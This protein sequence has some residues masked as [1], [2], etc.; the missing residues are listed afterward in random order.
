MIDAKIA[1]LALALSIERSVLVLTCRSKLSA[2]ACVIAVLAHAVGIVLFGFVRAL[3]YNFPVLLINLL[4]FGYAAAIAAFFAATADL[5]IFRM[6][7]LA[8][9]IILT[10][11][12]RA[13]LRFRY[14]SLGFAS[15]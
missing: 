14:T 3:S 13:R 8:L 4:N 15:I 10:F 7:G 11:L 6:R 1:I 2:A 9:R 5:S 12:G